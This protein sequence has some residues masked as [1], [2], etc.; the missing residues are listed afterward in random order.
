MNKEVESIHNKIPPSFMS[1]RPLLD[2][3]QPYQD[4]LEYVAEKWE[5]LEEVEKKDPKAYENLIA[6]KR[7]DDIEWDSLEELKD[8]IDDDI[9]EIHQQLNVYD[10]LMAQYNELGLEQSDFC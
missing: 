10:D 7:R 8:L 2:Y 5:C 1:W 3:P 6:F 9:Q 4:E